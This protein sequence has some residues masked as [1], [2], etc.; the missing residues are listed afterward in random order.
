MKFCY[1]FHLL[2]KLCVPA[3]CTLPPSAASVR[4]GRSPGLSP[5]C[6]GP[7]AVGLRE[8]RGQAL[9]EGAEPRARGPWRA[10]V[11]SSYIFLL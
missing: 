8:P 11:Q 7:R 2:K 6:P 3:L 4:G 5:A 1:T 10:C 9:V